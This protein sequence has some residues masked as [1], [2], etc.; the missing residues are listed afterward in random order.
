MTASEATMITGIC[1]VQ[2]WVTPNAS[3]LLSACRAMHGSSDPVF[4]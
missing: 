3:A 1:H 4:A 2:L